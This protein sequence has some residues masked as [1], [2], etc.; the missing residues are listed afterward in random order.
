MIVLARL[1]DRFGRSERR[2]AL[3]DAILQRMLLFSRMSERLGIAAPES[4]LARAVLREAELGCFECTTWR[5]CRKWLD[6]RSPEDDYHDFC[7]N[8]GL[9]DVLPRQ[10]C[11]KRPYASE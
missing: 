8:E 6:G 4:P 7:P 11:V 2:R 9:L 5:R 10:D 3:L 1:T